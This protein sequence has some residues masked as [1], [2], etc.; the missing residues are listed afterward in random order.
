MKAQ[1]KWFFIGLIGLLILSKLAFALPSA[2]SPPQYIS[3]SSALSGLANRSV[4]AKGTITT[5]TL[6]ANQQDFKWKAYIG[7]ISGKVALDNANGQSIYD[8]NLG[9][10]GGGEVYVSRYSNI[11]WDNIACV[12]QASIDA[13]QTSLGILPNAGDNINATFNYT[14]HRSFTVGAGSGIITLSNCRSTATYISD[15]PQVMGAGAFFQ[16]VLLRDT[17]TGR[18]VYTTFIESGHTGFDN[19]PHDF[20]LLVA[21]NESATVP[22]TYFFWVELG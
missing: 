17:G 10:A 9:T 4:D 13:E 6:S 7:N 15:N 22:S 12:N 14:N 20:Q 2:P 16:E 1:T 3:N 5:I 21:E 18:M 19:Q 8:W 11:D